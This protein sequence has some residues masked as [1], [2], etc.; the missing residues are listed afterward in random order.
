MIPI[1]YLIYPIFLILTT[2]IAGFIYR[3]VDGTHDFNDSHKYLGYGKQFREW[4]EG[5]KGIPHNTPNFHYRMLL[6]SMCWD[7]R[8][9]WNLISTLTTIYLPISCMV[10]L[11]V[12]GLSIEQ[13]LFG[14]LLVLG[15][16]GIFRFNLVGNILV[17]STA[18][19]FSLL[20]AILLLQGHTALG[21]L[22]ACIAALTKETSPIFIALF[23]QNP[24]ALL[25]FGSLLVYIIVNKPL[26]Q[27]R[28]NTF[29]YGL[30]KLKQNNSYD[31]ILKVMVLPWGLLC[32]ALIRPTGWLLLTLIAAY[33][34]CLVSTDNARLYQ[35]AFPVMIYLAVQYIPVQYMFIAIVVHLL[36]PWQIPSYNKRLMV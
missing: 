30:D 10:Y 14:G 28:M 8:R 7:T 27:A 18:L 4:I 33:S 20:S 26:R 21:I 11:H 29:K 23:S 31:Y 6:P 17:D 22:V 36:N 34:Q 15:L 13:S 24:I 25:G 19:M 1:G 3:K 12:M 5:S 35:W 2:C 32:I 9:L 16:F